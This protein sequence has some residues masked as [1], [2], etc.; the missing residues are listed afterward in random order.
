MGAIG[1]V[2]SSVSAYEIEDAN[3]R[4]SDDGEWSHVLFS[5][6]FLRLNGWSVFP[7]WEG[8]V[9]RLRKED[10]TVIDFLSR[11]CSFCEGRGDSFLRVAMVERVEWEYSKNF[12]A[13]TLATR[14]F[15][16]TIE[17]PSI[18]FEVSEDN[19]PYWGGG[20]IWSSGKGF[21][22]YF[23]GDNVSAIAGQREQ[24][25]ELLGVSYAYCR[26]RFVETNVAH[27]TAPDLI[28]AYVRFFDEFQ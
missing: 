28:E 15:D 25:E 17:N 7:L 5:R 10:G 24:V 11:V 3:F 18:L 22:I 16:L 19:L 1:F 2:A 21:I 8:D 13:L 14:E 12:T 9:R 6:E 4:E 26:E 23:D 20:F 27:Q